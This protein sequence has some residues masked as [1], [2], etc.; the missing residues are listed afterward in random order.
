MW[1]MWS[2]NASLVLNTRIEFSQR[3]SGTTTDIRKLTSPTKLSVSIRVKAPTCY[4]GVGRIDASRDSVN[5]ET[6]VESILC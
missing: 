3:T 6:V 2:F 5:E 4:T 1:P